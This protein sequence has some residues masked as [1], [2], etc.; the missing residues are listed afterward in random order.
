MKPVFAGTFYR[1]ALLNT[2]DAAHKRVIGFDC[3]KGRPPRVTT[4][5]ILSEFLTF[6]SG[7]GTLFRVKAVG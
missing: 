7:E 4:D 6:F 2:D 5:E 3:A 1:L